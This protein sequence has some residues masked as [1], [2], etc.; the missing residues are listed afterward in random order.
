[1]TDF[2]FA[3]TAQD[4]EELTTEMV[5]AMAA[6]SFFWATDENLVMLVEEE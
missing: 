3:V 6:W 1:M 4:G 5:E 2:P